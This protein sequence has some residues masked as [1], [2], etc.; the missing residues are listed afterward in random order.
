MSERKEGSR[1][2]KKNERRVNRGKGEG[3]REIFDSWVG[4]LLSFFLCLDS[5]HHSNK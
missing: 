2:G 4:G 1:E 3:A 5:T